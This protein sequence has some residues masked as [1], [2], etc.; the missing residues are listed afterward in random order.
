MQDWYLRF[1]LTKAKGVAEVASIGG[2]VKPTPSP[3]IRG[4]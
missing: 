4:G 1:A 2:F 3:S